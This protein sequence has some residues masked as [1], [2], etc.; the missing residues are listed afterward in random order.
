[1]KYAYKSCALS[2]IRKFVYWSHAF[3]D[4]ILKKTNWNLDLFL[5]LQK[6]ICFDL[7]GKIEYST[8]QFAFKMI[9]NITRNLKTMSNVIFMVEC[10]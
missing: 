5:F 3:K 8:L 2:Y 9:N 7:T 6:S 1:M 10:C 4:K